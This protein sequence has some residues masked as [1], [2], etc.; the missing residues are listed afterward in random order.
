MSSES[1]VLGLGPPAVGA[2]AFQQQAAVSSRAPYPDLQGDS[3][4]RVSG[5]H[6]W[7]RLV[8]PSARPP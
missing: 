6:G 5:L 4:P 1:S 7:R 8:L 2:T 3:P